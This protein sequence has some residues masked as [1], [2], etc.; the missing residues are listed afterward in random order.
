MF[1]YLGPSPLMLPEP[2]NLT[3]PNPDSLSAPNLNMVL[4]ATRTPP[5]MAVLLCCAVLTPSH[6]LHFARSSLRLLVPSNVFSTLQL[7]S[8]LSSGPTLRKDP[9]IVLLMYDVLH[10]LH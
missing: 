9:S 5:S 8:K 2:N 10:V 7:T 4:Q 1:S 6:L 3:A